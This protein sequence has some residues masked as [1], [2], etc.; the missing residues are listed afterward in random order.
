[1]DFGEAYLNW[2]F[3]SSETHEDTTLFKGYSDTNILGDV[4]SVWIT[5]TTWE[6]E[7]NR[8]YNEGTALAVVSKD[9]L[10]KIAVIFSEDKEEFEELRASATKVAAYN[11]KQLDSPVKFPYKYPVFL[12]MMGHI[13]WRI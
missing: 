2:T 12:T 10:Y 13:C 9:E 6:Q 3:V 4:I 8:T 5:K 1:M 11:L 7:G